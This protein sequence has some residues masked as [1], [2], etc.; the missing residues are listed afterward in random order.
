MKSE[1]SKIIVLSVLILFLT[2]C[3]KNYVISEKQK[4]LFQFEYVNY[5][6]GYQHKGFLIDNEGNILTYE[7]PENWNFRDNNQNI[8]E[9]QVSE[10]ISKCS[11]SG[12]KIQKEELQKY[13]NY[14][15]NIASTK[16]SAL[17]N[18]AADAGSYEYFCYQYSESSETYRGYLIKMEGDFTCENLNYYSKKVAVWM[19]ELNSSLQKK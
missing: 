18:V 4:I 5:A 10:N 12:K 17:K 15:K 16:I 2:G 8:S 19:K 13:T 14:I 9:I 1:L 6:W 7:N 11:Y 3:K